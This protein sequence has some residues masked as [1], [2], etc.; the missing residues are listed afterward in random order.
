[1]GDHATG[2]ESEGH[3]SICDCGHLLAILPFRQPRRF[4]GG[5]LHTSNRGVKRRCLAA[6]A[7]LL[8]TRHCRPSPFSL[9]ISLSIYLSR[10]GPVAQAHSQSLSL[11]L[12]LS[13]SPSLPPSRP[14]SLP[15][16]SPS[17]THFLSRQRVPWVSVRGLASTSPPLHPPSPSSTS[18]HDAS[19][20]S[21]S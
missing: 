9:S 1:M 19:H 10:R 3:G 2:G 8:E 12:S 5:K 7:A 6:A 11:S 13:L 21:S 20:S 14:P 18:S 16:S 17:L 4:G 15:P